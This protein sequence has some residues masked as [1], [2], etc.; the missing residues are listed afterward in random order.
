MSC[1]STMI[2]RLRRMFW[3]VIHMR[4]V[5]SIAIFQ[6]GTFFT[7]GLGFVSSVIYPRL[8]GLEAFG[9][10]AV[11]SAFIGLGS[12]CMSYGQETSTT[13]FLAEAQGRKN[14]KAMQNVLRY[15]V[16]MTIISTL[17]G[18]VFFVIAPLLASTLQGDVLVGTLGR[19]IILN[20]M[21]QPPIFL[22]FLALQLEHR[23][24][25][26][27]FLESGSDVAQV[28]LCTLL[29]LSGWGVEGILLGTLAVSIVTAPIFILMYERS[30]KRQGLPSLRSVV[31][32]I[33][34][35]NGT[36]GY[37]LQG[38]WIALDRHVGRNAYPNLFIVILDRIAPREVVG[39]FK[40]G[41]KL[42]QLPAE[43][44]NSGISRLSSVSIPKIA[45][46]DRKALKRSCI[47]LLSVTL[48][49]MTGAVLGAIVCVPLFV[50]IVYGQTFIG[51]IPI[52]L[53]IVP[54]NFFSAMNVASVP[55]ARVYRKVWMMTLINL[56]GI[57]VSISLFFLVF[58]HFFPLGIAM[59]LCVLY[60]HAHSLLLYVFLYYD[61]R[62]G[63]IAHQR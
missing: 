24:G 3:A 52:F 59:G 43:L 2:S 33:A 37:V 36:S 10:Y 58:Q 28:I 8:I 63:T 61:I 12:M 31:P 26:I 22:L 56:T 60:Y 57:G 9:L 44:V 46:Q 11:V 16:Q 45:T 27:V 6:V 49:I 29:L 4:F 40:I 23:I 30:A 5:Q 55:L 39:L 17:M 48:A 35:F 15:Y 41:L 47:R 25:T 18:I 42:A 7:L 34:S 53:T 62:R 19:L 54:F 13:T 32:E 51:V 14:P 38:L 50:P 1:T 21:L 20:T